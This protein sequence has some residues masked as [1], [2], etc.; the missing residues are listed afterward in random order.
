MNRFIVR[1]AQIRD[2]EGIHRLAHMLNTMNLPDEVDALQEV[3]GKSNQSFCG[4]IRDPFEREYLFVVEDR[5]TGQVVGSSQ[6]IAQHGTRES[7]HIFFDVSSVERY[8]KSIDRLFKHQVLRLGYNYDGPTEVGGLI[9]DPVSF[10][11]CLWV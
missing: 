10:V 8:S 4:Q 3:I 7:P 5:L 2:L 1:N 9:V 6:I 11:S